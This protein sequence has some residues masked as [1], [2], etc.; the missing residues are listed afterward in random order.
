[1]KSLSLE[2]RVAVVIGGTRLSGGEGNVGRTA[3]GVV[4]L[5]I[6]N[7]GLLNL[8]LTDAYFQL[9]R[10]LALLAV[11]SVQIVVR[12]ATDEEE[13]RKR[14]HEQLSAAMAGA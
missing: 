14:E 8:G 3:L 1:M 13:R 12:H 5:S 7:S 4:F 10:G 9:Y 6:L 11:L 2:N